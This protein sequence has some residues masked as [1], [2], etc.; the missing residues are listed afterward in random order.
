M[1]LFFDV[2]FSVVEASTE[3]NT[4]DYFFKKMIHDTFKENQR[5]KYFKIVFTI[6]IE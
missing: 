3:V 5:S 1:V 2:Y 4:R 6:A